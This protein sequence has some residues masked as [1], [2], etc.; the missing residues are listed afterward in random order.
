[1][2]HRHREHRIRNVTTT[3][4]RTG[5]HGTNIVV[6]TMMVHMVVKTEVGAITNQ[7]MTMTMAVTTVYRAKGKVTVA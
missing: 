7:M 5:G 2:A 3:D 6:A 4:R 1:M